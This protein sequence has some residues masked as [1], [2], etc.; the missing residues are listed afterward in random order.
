MSLLD[1]KDWDELWDIYP[2]QYAAYNWILENSEIVGRSDSTLVL[3]SRLIQ[4]TPEE[5][6]WMRK[7]NIDYAPVEMFAFRVFNVLSNDGFMKFRQVIKRIESGTLKNIYL[8]TKPFTKRED[9]PEILHKWFIV[10]GWH[11]IKGKAYGFY[12]GRDR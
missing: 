12:T 7:N 1:E 10:T 3:H 11:D 6:G 8:I 2:T 4:Y 5:R 9:I